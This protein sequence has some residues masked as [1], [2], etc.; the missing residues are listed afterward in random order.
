MWWKCVLLAKIAVWSLCLAGFIFRI[1]WDLRQASFFYL[2]PQRLHRVL[3]WHSFLS[4]I[5]CQSYRLALALLHVSVILGSWLRDQLLSYPMVEGEENWLNIY[6]K[7]N[8]QQL[9]GSSKNRGFLVRCTK[10]WVSASVPSTIMTFSKL[11]NFFETGFS[12][13][14]MRIIRNTCLFNYFIP[15][16]DIHRCLLC[17][18]QYPR[19]GPTKVSETGIAPVFIQLMVCCEKKITDTK[20]LV[21]CLAFH[22][23]SVN[24]LHWPEV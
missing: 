13:Y 10:I 11:L 5:L 12:I 21:L 22:R 23:H 2:E 24:V 20:H 18:R 1:K 6:R 14:N 3:Q 9:W 8:P 4:Q 15:S 7:E 19:S 16:T 17:T